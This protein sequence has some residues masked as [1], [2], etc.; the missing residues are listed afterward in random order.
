MVKTNAE[1]EKKGR[2]QKK[3]RNIAVKTEH[4]KIRSR[5]KKNK[6]SKNSKNRRKSI[7]SLKIINSNIKGIKNRREGK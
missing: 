7:K 4:I 5:I 3:R 2:E 6:N 1:D